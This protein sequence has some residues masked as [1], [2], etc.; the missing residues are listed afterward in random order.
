[1]PNFTCAN[2]KCEKHFYS[3]KS[4]SKYCSRQ[5][6]NEMNGTKNLSQGPKKAQKFSSQE[7]IEMLVG[8][9]AKLG[10]TPSKRDVDKHL[11]AKSRTYSSRFG[12]YRNAAVLAGFEPNLPYPPSF[13]KEERAE[14]PLSLRFTILQRDQFRCQ[15]C[16]GTPQ[17]GYILHVDHKVPKS[18][19][20]LAEEC[21]L[22]TS[23]AFCN[24]GKSDITVVH[25]G[26][27]QR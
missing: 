8:L 18:Q 24:M 4:R 15:Y 7:M 16:G 5:C 22:I 26:I 12:T 25:R 21:N 6:S 2:S 9:G 27:A 20:G 17:D 3:K 14:V 13:M 10:K 1:M 23:C 19:G 11:P